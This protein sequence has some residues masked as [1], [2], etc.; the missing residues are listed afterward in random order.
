MRNEYYQAVRRAQ[1]RLPKNQE[2]WTREDYINSCLKMVVDMAIKYSNIT[3]EDTEELIAEGNLGLATAYEKYRPD[4][5]AKFSSV[6]YFWIKA[7]MLNYIAKNTPSAEMQSIERDM[8]DDWDVEDEV[9]DETEKM[10]F[11][12]GLTDEEI[13]IIKRRFGIGQKKQTLASIRK[14]YPHF[15]GIRAI[16]NKINECLEVIKD[17][18]DKYKLD[19]SKFSL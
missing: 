15:I 6:A 16:T 11:L 2:E 5:N 3:G 1:N 9:D 13:D 10:K 7:F 19:S 18:S 8:D 17:N 12:Q 14:L 4:S